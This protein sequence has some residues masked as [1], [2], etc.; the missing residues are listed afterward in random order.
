MTEILSARLLLPFGAALLALAAAFNPSLPLKRD[1]RDA[2]VVVDVTRSMNTRDMKGLSRLDAAR[3]LLRDWVAGQPCGTRIGLAIFTERRSLTMFEP[4]EVCADFATLSA[5]LEALNW[6]MAWEGDSMISRGLDHALGRARELEVGLIFATDGHEAPPLPYSGPNRFAGESPGG[7]ILGLGGET[8]SPIPKFDDRG[9]E[10]G[11]YGPH[12]VQHAPARIGPPPTDAESRPGFHPRNNPY[13]EA[14]LEGAEHLSALRLD[15]LRD[16]A[17]GRGLSVVEAAAGPQ[18]LEA[19]FAAQVPARRI[20]APFG[21]GP[22]LGGLALAL[23]LAGW[24]APPPKTRAFAFPLRPASG[25]P[26]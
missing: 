7:V 23:L 6:R 13:G 21:L 16:L 2:L 1:L 24:F 18:A 19:A 17:A 5:A 20:S 15:H 3:G 26:P 9:R 10:S 11:F 4:V 12:D 22:I 14:D 8:P 25:D